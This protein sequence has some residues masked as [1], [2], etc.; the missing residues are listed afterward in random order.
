MNSEPTDSERNIRIDPADLD[1]MRK[2]VNPAGNDYLAYKAGV[3]E[4]GGD[5]EY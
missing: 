3:K 4:P 2:Q 1:K 5:D